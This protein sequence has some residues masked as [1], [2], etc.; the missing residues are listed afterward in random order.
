ML[1]TVY[2]QIITGPQFLVTVARQAQPP[3]AKNLGQQWFH[4]PQSV[5]LWYS[6]TG[7]TTVSDIVV[8]AFKN[9]I[10]LL[11]PYFLF[12][13]YLTLKHRMFKISFKS[14]ESYVPMWKYADTGWSFARSS[15]LNNFIFGNVLVT[16]S[17]ANYYGIGCPN[18]MC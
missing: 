2:C 8:S 11:H 14:S 16:N 13:F 4:H 6:H 18:I 17:T 15:K 12:Y 3:P 1:L 5:N 7:W 10:C 9:F